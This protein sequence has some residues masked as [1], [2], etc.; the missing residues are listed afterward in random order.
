MDCDP[1]AAVRVCHR[2][3]R[4]NGEP[5][6]SITARH[7]QSCRTRH[8][9]RHTLV[10]I[11]WLRGHH[12][13]QRVYGPDLMLAC[14]EL[15]IRKG[16]AF[17]ST[18]AVRAWQSGWPHA[19]GGALMVYRSSAHRRPVPRPGL[20]CLWQFK[21]AGPSGSSGGSSS[22]SSKST[23]GRSLWM[24][25]FFSRRYPRV[26]SG[27]AQVRFSLV[28]C[29]VGDVQHFEFTAFRSSG[30]RHQ[31]RRLHRSPSRG[32]SEERGYRCAAWV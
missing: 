16:S 3:A 15:S 31:R 25:G 12:H 23:P 17:F 22:T 2:G 20:T 5:G 28:P 32:F 11:S 6:R 18:A 29:P 4:S 10:W 13:V 14:C 1:C 7:S 9:R 30:L 19:P 27:T 26:V 24:R 21:A 8:A